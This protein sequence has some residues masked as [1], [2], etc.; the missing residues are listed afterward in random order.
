[1]IKP[2]KY[3]RI[4]RTALAL[5]CVSYIVYFLIKNKQDLKV[6]FDINP[7]YLTLF[8][9][10]SIL[11]QSLVAYRWR[12]VLHK[13]SG[14]TIA[15][16]KWL[17]Y[18]ILGRF[19]NLIAPQLGNLYRSVALKKDYGITYTDYISSMASYTWM[20]T[21]LNLLFAWIVIAVVDIRLK[22]GQVSAL[23]IVT[24]ILIFAFIMPVIFEYLFSKKMFKR[25]FLKWAQSKVH[26]VLT[27]ALQ[28]VRDVNFIFKIIS[29][30]VLAFVYTIAM[31]YFC[32]KVFDITI[33]LP[34]L[35]LFYVIMR[36][37]NLVIIT[38]GNIGLREIA[39]GIIGSQ[40]GISMTEG[41]IISIILRIVNNL[42]LLVLGT[43]Y[44]GIGLLKRKNEIY[45]DNK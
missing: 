3:S 26:E 17:R 12:I 28:N 14:K 34:A 38:P 2:N 29:T 13:C 15:F 42:V 33:S 39:Y 41:I 5:G 45:S 40:I 44:G 37:S 25:K 9:I 16:F 8:F 21:C 32:F 20:D 18:F 1:M 23:A 36:I 30:A 31:L 43:L 27:T 35:S 10:F 7:I 19:L 6:V 22:I 4:L 11:G 24:L